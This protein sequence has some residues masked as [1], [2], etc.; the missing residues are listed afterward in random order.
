MG[1]A[2]QP[3][4]SVGGDLHADPAPAGMLTGEPRVP[5][6]RRPPGSSATTRSSTL[7]IS[8]P[9]A[10]QGLAPP[11]RAAAHLDAAVL[12][13]RGGRAG[14]RPPPLPR[15][16][17]GRPRRP[18]ATRP[19][20]AAP[21]S[22]AWQLDRRLTDGAAAAAVAASIGPADRQLWDA[23]LD[24]LPAGTVIVRNG[25]PQLVGAAT[26]QRFSFAGWGQP[27]RRGAPARPRCSPRQPPWRPFA[28]GFVR[29]CTPRPRTD[30]SC[31]P[32]PARSGRSC[33]TR[34]TGSA[35]GATG[36]VPHGQPQR[37]RR[38]P[39]HRRGVRV[40]RQRRWPCDR[41]RGRCRASAPGRRPA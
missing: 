10:V 7:W 35:A 27:V 16:P 17:A 3:S 29:R 38:P 20:A 8:C 39:R 36:E 4:R 19:T 28:G 30:P 40:A 24:A 14:R 23:D 33:R 22:K 11:A 25:H 9:A 12:P 37:R 15:V 18:T 31:R 41:H 2:P 26:R 13:R 6:G 1:P 21:R 34:T 32:D 5:R